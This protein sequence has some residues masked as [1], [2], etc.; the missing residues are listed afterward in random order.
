[1]QLGRLNARAA[2]VVAVGSLALLISACGSAPGPAPS[3]TPAKPTSTTR[4]PSTSTTVESTSAAVLQAYRSSWSAFEH[5]LADANPSDPDLAAPGTTPVLFVHGINSGPWAWTRGDVDGMGEPPLQYVQKSLGNGKV[6]GY[7]FDWSK[8]AGGQG[9]P[10]LWVTSPLPTSLGADLSQAIACV[11]RNSGHQV[12]I[13]A[14][15]MGGLITQD[16]SSLVR[17]DIA[18]VFT[19]GTPYQGSWAASAAGG[20]R[21]LGGLDLVAQVIRAAC[22][23]QASDLLCIYA[24]EQH[25]PGVE[26][27]RLD[28][29]GGWKARPAWPAGLPV[30][31]LAGSVTGT[32]QPVW[33]L[34]I[35][36]PLIDAG[37]VVVGTNSQ[38]ASWPG[39]TLSCPVRLGLGSPVGT[40]AA[41]SVL[42]VLDTSLCFHWNEP[43]TRA[44][45]DHHG[46][47]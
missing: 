7:T 24:A 43:D 2:V 46:S 16:A 11:A 35:Q 1:M 14:H 6:T 15:S 28:P 33:P 36:V 5:A 12:I 13:I 23:F 47:A 20:Q 26:A 3:A 4:A 39:T 32:W 19:L 45:L 37:D 8:Y 22:G 9:N 27:M 18:S 38:R 17:A 30:Y 21:L 29:A 31:S 44:L 42:D 41:L 40:P 25:D 10:V 34:N